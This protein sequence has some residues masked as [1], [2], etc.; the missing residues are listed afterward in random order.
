M[1]GLDLRSRK[2][3]KEKVDGEGEMETS[4]IDI[5]VCNKIIKKVL[6]MKLVH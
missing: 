3:V 1:K 6:S 2:R 5:V 4:S